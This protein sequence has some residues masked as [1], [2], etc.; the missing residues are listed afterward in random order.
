MTGY[1]QKYTIFY[2]K[3]FKDAFFLSFRTTMYKQ[4][5]R[6]ASDDKKNNKGIDVYNVQ[7]KTT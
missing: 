4:N 7:E 1:E 3:N 2:V 5:F 6:T